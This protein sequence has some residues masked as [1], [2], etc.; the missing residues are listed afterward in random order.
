[1]RN[2]QFKGLGKWLNR[3][4]KIVRKYTFLFKINCEKY[5]FLIDLLKCCMCQT[6]YRFYVRKTL[7]LRLMEN[8]E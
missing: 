1:M 5:E 4:L 8:N 7:H 2:N 6:S 3:T